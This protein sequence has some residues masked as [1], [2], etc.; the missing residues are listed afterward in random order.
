MTN[1][2][3]Y[4]AGYKIDELEE[5]AEKHF[6]DQYNAALVNI[7][8]YRE[9]VDNQ[10]RILADN[11]NELHYWEKVACSLELNVSYIPLRFEFRNAMEEDE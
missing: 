5:F 7:A 6:K 9:I 4:S 8:E 3:S 10:Q 1:Q 11:L 2:E